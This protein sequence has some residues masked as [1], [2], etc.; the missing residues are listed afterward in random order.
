L[1]HGLGLTY[2]R[3][4]ISKVGRVLA[5]CSSVVAVASAPAAAAPAVHTAQRCYR[6]GQPVAVSG[7]GFAPSRAVDLS[8]DG[9]DFGQTATAATGG[10]SG[11][12]TP[13]G[14]GAGQAQ[15]VDSLLATDGTSSATTTFTVTRTAGARF[16]ASRGNP[17]KLLAPFEVWGFSMNGTRRAVY[18]HYVSPSGGLRTTVALGT[19]SGQ[20][21][22]LRTPKRRFFPFT[23]S[24][25]RWVLQVDT[26]RGYTPRPHGP[27]ARI[28]V[29]ITGG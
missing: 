28:R 9:V 11:T 18:V 21:G 17:A 1:Y 8:I 2:L 29:A 13:G 26:R 7:V 5:I 24:A 27:V 19:V 4:P 12:I 23:P 25:G 10:F 3:T 22:Y 14:L 16:I 20:C 15:A 6:V